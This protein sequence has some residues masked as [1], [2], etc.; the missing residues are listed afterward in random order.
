MQPACVSVLL[1]KG[2]YTCLALFFSKVMD[3]D[4]TSNMHALHAHTHALFPA[5]FR[6]T[7]LSWLLRNICQSSSHT[8]LYVLH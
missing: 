1:W 4:I 2:L 5:I 7:C 6:L 8:E 3:N